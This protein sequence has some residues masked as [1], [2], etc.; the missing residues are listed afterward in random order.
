MRW[1]GGVQSGDPEMIEADPDT[2][3]TPTPP[4]PAP[5]FF[6]S[7]EDVMQLDLVTGT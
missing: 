1:R 6:T 5:I 2:L 7:N 3:V 4:T